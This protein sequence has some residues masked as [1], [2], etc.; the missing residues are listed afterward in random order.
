M[1]A[2]MAAQQNSRAEA[3]SSNFPEILQARR[4]SLHNGTATPAVMLVNTLRA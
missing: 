1:T 3:V 2:T 4:L